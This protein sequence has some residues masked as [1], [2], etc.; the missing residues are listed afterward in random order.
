MGGEVTEK[1]FDQWLKNREPGNF[2]AR[3]HRPR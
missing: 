3:F 1:D 2:N